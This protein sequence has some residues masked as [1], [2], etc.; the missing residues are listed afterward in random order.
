MSGSGSVVVTLA[1]C[2]DGV[3]GTPVTR[4]GAVLGGDSLRVIQGAPQGALH[5]SP[6]ARNVQPMSANKV[7]IRIGDVRFV[8][9]KV[10]VD[11]CWQ[12]CCE[13]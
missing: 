10:A 13:W 5:P 12:K 1:V 11:Y 3:D 7:L 9:Q 6:A 4:G 8:M 2:S